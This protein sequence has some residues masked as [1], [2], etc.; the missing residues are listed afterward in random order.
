MNNFVILDLEWNGAYCKSTESFINEIIEFGA[1]KF[2]ENFKIIDSFSEL[3]KPKITKKISGK[4]KKLTK[5]TN[6]ELSNGRRYKDVLEEFRKFLGSCILLTWSTSD[7]IALIENN[8][9]FLQTDKIP[10][11]KKYVDLQKYCEV[12]LGQEK[13]GAQ[14]GLNTSVELLGID[15]KEYELHR[16][17]DDS[18][19]SFE[20]FKR[21]YS[22]KKL[23]S[24][25][26]DCTTDEFY[27]KLTFKTVILCDLDNPLIDKSVMFFNCN[28]CN[29]RAIQLTDWQFKGKTYRA[30]FNCPNCNID[31]QG[32]IQ[33][34]LKYEGLLVIK[35]VYPIYE[36]L[37]EE[38]KAIN[39]MEIE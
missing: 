25:I 32:R 2:D 3:V 24:F 12:C 6:K 5:I 11:L 26:Q 30:N 10:F 15:Y 38:N 31:F 36:E 18:F 7:L 29:E 14:M 4:I 9:I 13:Q 33:F 23:E 28:N 37:T 27:N 1:I 16:A 8:K 39:N 34:K 20:C 17:L 22:R 19:L 35:K 21:L